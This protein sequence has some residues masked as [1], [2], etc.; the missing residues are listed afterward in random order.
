MSDDDQYAIPSDAP[1]YR[2]RPGDLS[3]LA[4][5]GGDPFKIREGR[6]DRLSKW[7]RLFTL[8]WLAWELTLASRHPFHIAKQAMIYAIPDGQEHILDGGC[9]FIFAF[10]L[11][12]MLLGIEPTKL[13]LHPEHLNS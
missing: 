6:S 5:L 13:T 1:P 11:A 8:N 10:D 12:A 3:L 4:G 2:P 7:H 9:E